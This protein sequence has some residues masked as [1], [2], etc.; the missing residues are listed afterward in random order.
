MRGFRGRWVTSTLIV[1]ASIASVCVTSSPS[2]NEPVDYVRPDI[3]GIS[4]L[5]TSTRPIVQLPH[6]YPQVTPM[7]NPGITDSYL[8]TKIYGFPAGGV[9]LMPTTGNIKTD[10]NDIA[11]NFDRDF[12]TRTPYYYKGL[13]EDY[14][15]EASCTVGHFAIFYRFRFPSVGTR[16]VNIMMANQGSMRI[17]SPATIEGST[18]IHE[19]P[20]YFYLKFSVP[21]VGKSAWKYDGKS[22]VVKRLEGEKIGLT[23]NFAG[24]GSELV[25]V[26]VGL[27]FISLA[28]AEKNLNEAIEGWNFELRRQQTKS[29]WNKLLGKIDVEGGTEKQKIILYS[30]LYRAEENM[31]DITEDGRYYSGFDHKVHN[32][33]GIDFYT[34]DQLWD[35]FRCEH[36]LQLLLDPKQQE[37]MIQ[38]LVRMDEQ[39]GWLPSFPSVGGEFA[40]MIGDHSDELIADT[41]FKGWRNFEVERAYEA[42]KHEALHATMLPW[43]RGKMTA[44]GKTY[45]E[46]GFFPALKEGEKETNPEVHP[47]E[48]RQAVSVTLEAAYDDWCIAIMAKALGHTADYDRFIKMAD[49]YKNVFDRSTGF[50]APKS[51]DG[52]WVKGFNPTLPK[53]P[54]GRDYFTEMNAWVWTFNVPHDVAGLIQLFGGR[55]PFLHKLDSLFEEQYGGLPKYVFLAKFPDMTGLIGNYAQGNEPSFD[56]AYMYDFAGEPWKT[57]KMIRE[58]MEA[59]YHDMPLGLPGDDDQGAMGAWYVFSA[60]GFY[61]FCPG[62]P[63][64]V[65][66]SPLFAKTTIHLSNGRAFTIRAEDVSTRN[67]Y[68][69]S[70]TLDGNPLTKPWFTQQDIA[71]GGTLE[72][73]MGSRPNKRWGSAPGEAPPSQSSAQSQPAAT[74]RSTEE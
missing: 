52:A 23:L 62:N 72:L 29:A 20:S 24:S 68:I 70:A 12:E 27:S 30:S 34:H 3:G 31:M 65:I 7:L 1:F 45:L 4:I 64:Y 48:R 60:M 71:E 11:S 38:S 2:E 44:L 40:A 9:S 51:A 6:D 73:H 36:P 22:G 42:M 41:Y 25:Q 66:G 16:R 55:K 39:W 14:D 8:A 63:Y 43:R 32:S 33:H 69:Q 21:F 26:K 35:T 15:I 17:V 50:M 37:D 10:S 28:Q 49:N 56:V 19:V 67:K 53:G 5:L 47:F 46:K 18:S 57:Q 61:P 59:W 13:L 74:G 58:I 54:G